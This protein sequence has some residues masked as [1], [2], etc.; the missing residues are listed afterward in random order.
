MNFKNAKETL[1]KIG[2][3]HFNTLHCLG[4]A[5]AVVGANMFLGKLS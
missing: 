3:L 5:R 1:K 2:V 4:K